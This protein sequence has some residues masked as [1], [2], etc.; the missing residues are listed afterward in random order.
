DHRLVVGLGRTDV[1]LAGRGRGKVQGG[2]ALR[3]RRRRFAQRDRLIARFKQVVGVGGVVLQPGGL[4]REPASLGERRRRRSV[5]ADLIAVV[6]DRY[7]VAFIE[8]ALGDAGAIN[9]N[10]VG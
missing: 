3:Q 7:L 4:A 5:P 2:A 10:A 1:G 8:S 9:A 6:A